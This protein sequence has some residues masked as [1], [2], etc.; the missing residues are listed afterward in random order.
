[1]KK[2]LLYLASIVLFLAT[3]VNAQTTWSFSTAASTV[4][5]ISTNNSATIVPD[6]TNSITAKKWGPTYNTGTAATIIATGFP[7]LE[8][9]YKNSTATNYNI[10]FLEATANNGFFQA[11]G[12]D[13]I[14]T[15]TGCT[16]GQNIAVQYSAKG[17]TAV[18]AT[19]FV[20]PTGGSASVST[21]FPPNCTVNTATTTATSSTGTAD[22][23][24]V[25]LTV[26]ANGNVNLLAGSP[27]F[28]IFQIVKGVTLGT[29]S[30]SKESDVTVY[31]KDKKIFFSNIKSSTQVDVYDL[32]GA[33]VK[34][35]KT[36][37]DSDLDLKSGIYIVKL[38]SAE[39]E[40]S[41]KV[42]VQ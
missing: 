19:D 11:N 12:K 9:G 39:G 38:K 30:F 1:M 35:A 6:P 41:V 13:V 22:I 36:D 27:G 33:L 28:R 17:A 7:G 18:L 42:I 37:S 29:N 10:Q 26:T 14:V 8:F 31:S 40:K 2:N 5:T 21:A 15:I 24:V 3:S 4:G 32:T 34:S 23:Q 25:N 20:S 16:A